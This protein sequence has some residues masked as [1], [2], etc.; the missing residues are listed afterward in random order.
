VIA[1]IYGFLWVVKYEIAN[2]TLVQ[3]RKGYDA[4]IATYNKEEEKYMS[5]KVTQVYPNLYKIN[6]QLQT[7]TYFTGTQPAPCQNMG[8]IKYGSFGL[9]YYTGDAY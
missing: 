8:E 4:C 6:G 2:H 9:A 3:H 1:L 5:S 7:L